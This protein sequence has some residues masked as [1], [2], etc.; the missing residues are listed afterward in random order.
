MYPYADKTVFSDLYKS[1][2]LALIQFLLTVRI[3]K[4]R[5]RRI[6]RIVYIRFT[7]YYKM[8]LANIIDET[9]KTRPFR[10]SNSRSTLFFIFF[11][12]KNRLKFE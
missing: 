11:F 3:V 9:N 12:C 4:D 1:L 8:D 5:F 6:N 10:K 7:R 2:H